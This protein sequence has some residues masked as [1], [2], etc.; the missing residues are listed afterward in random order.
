MESQL[1]I[2]SISKAWLILS[3]QSYKMIGDLPRIGLPAQW[4]T[5]SPSLPASAS[6][7]S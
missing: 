2:S 4:G 6:S 3:T 7:L 5:A 1:L